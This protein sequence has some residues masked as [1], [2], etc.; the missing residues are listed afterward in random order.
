MNK[1]D[2]PIFTNNPWLI[3]LDKAASTQKPQYVIDGVSEFV[4]SSYAN[5]H[6][7][8]YAIS[9][10]SEELYYASKAKYAQLINCKTSE[11]IY[12]YNATYC[13]NLL[14]QSLCASKR[15]GKGDSVLLGIWDHHANIVPRQSLALEYGF[16]VKFI[17]ST[18]D[19]E[20]DR[21]DFDRQYTPDVK[22]VSCAHVSNVTG[23]IYEV[24]QIKPRLR[25]DTFFI[26]DGSQAIPNFTVDVMALGCDAYV[27]TAHKIMAYTGLGMLYLQKQHIK[28]L[29]PLIAWG[30]SISDVDT[31]GYTISGTASSFEAGTPNIIAA[32]SLLKALEYID[33]QGGMDAIWTHEQRLV[34]YA[35]PKFKALEDQGKLHLVG[36]YVAEKRVWAFSFVLPE[37]KN[38]SKIGDVFAAQNICVRCGGHCAYPLHKSLHL[39]GTCR[40]SVYGYND[41]HDIDRFFEVLEGIIQ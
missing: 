37:E 26:I 14:A 7:G 29:R 18:D 10:K 17:A 33:Q 5:I 11:I 34:T 19:Y 15:L 28:T 16:T 41:E 9:E 27:S 31:E 32:V 6:R 3:Y 13:I 21:A 36:P 8:L 4:A 35:L 1:S 20:I 38:T 40:M 23:A 24:D 2:F 22:V 25:P 39:A 30:G 12:S